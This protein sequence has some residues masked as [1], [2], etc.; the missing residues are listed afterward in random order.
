MRKPQILSKI[1]IYQFRHNC[2]KRKNAE[3]VKLSFMDKD[4]FFKGIVKDAE[5]RFATSN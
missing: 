1:V 5:E 3:K 2:I 4:C